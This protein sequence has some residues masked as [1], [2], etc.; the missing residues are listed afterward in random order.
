MA[1]PDRIV[2]I[3]A[4]LAGA[5]AA[6][7][8]RDQGFDGSITLVGEEPHLPYERPPLSKALLIGDTDEPDWVSEAGYYA[9]HDVTLLTGTTATAV[10]PGEQRVTAGGEDL[11]YDRLLLATGSS[12]R[13]LDV[14]GGDLDGVHYLRTLD[15]ALALRRRLTAGTRLVVVGAGWI[16]CE[17]A[18]A[19][20]SRGATV[21]VVAPESQPLVRVLGEQVGA[22]FAALHTDHGTELRLAS[23]VVGF[24]GDGHLEGVLL[25]GGGTLAA[26]AVVVGVGAVPNLALADAAGLELAGGGV[27]VDATLRTSAPGVYAAGDIAAHAHP[28]YPGRVRVEHWANAKDQGEHVAANLLG[29]DRPYTKRPFFFSDQYD[30]GCEYRG[31]A[32]PATDPLVVRGSLA[33]REYT[34]FWTRDGAVAAALNVN[35]WDDGDALTDLV[36]TGRP[37]TA[38]ELVHGDL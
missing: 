28:A 23:G 17:V 14:P 37:I 20:R 29:A 2:I 5:T 36:D 12:P 11:P 26:D 15:D 9:D 32:D 7:T 34:A 25:A 19:A 4:S 16:G 3:G 10:S 38:D 6:V 18:A 1:A 8:L 27:A 13:R 30:L 31:L 33:D 22:S 21:T 24:V 35:M